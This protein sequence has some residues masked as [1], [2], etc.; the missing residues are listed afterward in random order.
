MGDKSLIFL[1]QNL[2]HCC[3]KDNSKILEL[4]SE[5]F[6]TE[7]A[8][9]IYKILKN[10][11]ISDTDITIRNIEI[12]NDSIKTEVI[13]G[14]FDLDID[15]SEES[16]KVYL[17]KLKEQK[18]KFSI[19]NSLIPEIIEKTSNTD[20]SIED[21]HRIASDIL[22][23]YNNL[24]KDSIKTY[25]PSNMFHE[26]EK[27]L[28]NR[29]NFIDSYDTG[30]SYLDSC[31]LEK[32]RPGRI[33]TI[34]G[35]SGVG[36]SAYALFLVY[37]QLNKMIPSMFFTL[38]MTYEATMD[39]LVSQALDIPVTDLYP[40]LDENFGNFKINQDIVEGVKK[41]QKRFEDSEFFELIEDDALYI[42]DV[43]ARIKD[44]KI[45]NKVDYVV[46][47]IDLLTML[48]DF[49]MGNKN[50]ADKYED[51][52]NLLHEVSRR[53]NSHIIG[54][55]QQKRPQSRL[56]IKSIDQLDNFR[57]QLEDLK[58]SA[59]LQERSRTVLGVFRPKHFA[60]L[61]LPDEPETK[62]MP[63]I[64]EIDILKQNM[65]PLNR[66]KYLFY[67]E[68]YKFIKYVE[69]DYEVGESE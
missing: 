47:T 35:P 53:T 36:K 48:K 19:R 4:G 57:P 16:F 45:K 46:V 1:E 39:R 62:I 51:S 42:R 69:S 14:L 12:E 61:Y 49:N 52:M 28:N 32:F 54:V 6:I 50:K 8:V 24:N 26:Y 29:E 43:E 9:E 27:I 64:T 33:T 7:D 11:Y 20:S 34:F 63:D 38:E 30:C 13:K 44:F 10:L 68:T 15:S 37:R 5:I 17:N 41:M 31:L 66:I 65:G 67:P 25:T 59:A 60:N 40:V 18:F 2:I 21:I 23:E 58:N 56:N 55:V 22:N 3:I